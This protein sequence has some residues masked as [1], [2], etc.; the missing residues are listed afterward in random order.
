MI[1]FLKDNLD[2]VNEILV[3]SKMQYSTEN[4]EDILALQNIEEII[5]MNKINQEDFEFY[6]TYILERN[7]DWKEIYDNNTKNQKNK[8]I[9]ILGG[10]AHTI[11]LISRF[12]GIKFIEVNLRNNNKLTHKM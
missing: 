2:K 10:I 6:K 11:D 9:L 8:K 7:A 12:E 4:E 3:S 5:K 1:G